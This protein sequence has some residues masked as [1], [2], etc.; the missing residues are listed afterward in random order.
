MVDKIKDLKTKT[1]EQL[2][3]EIVSLRKEGLNLRFQQASGQ[4][5]N[6]NRRRQVK[7]EVAKIKTLLTERENAAKKSDKN[8]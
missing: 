4:L 2:E 6:T 1:D 8:A 7:R 3:E 5:T